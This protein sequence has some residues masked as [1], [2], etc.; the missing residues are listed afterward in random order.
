[1]N[2]FYVKPTINDLMKEKVKNLSR[3]EIRKGKNKIK[4]LFKNF[5]KNEYGEEH[6]LDDNFSIA[7]TETED[8]LF[9]ISYII[10]L[11]YI[12]GYQILEDYEKGK[13]YILCIDNYSSYD[14]MYKLNEFPDFSSYVYIDEEDL[15]NKTGFT[16]D[17]DGN[18]IKK[19]KNKA[20]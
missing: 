8:G 3:K 11:E 6:D 12:L 10:D 14:E 9:G 1:M 19:L 20:Y 16:L 5:M 18:I 2:D 7:F 4:K 15:Y 17:D 13:T